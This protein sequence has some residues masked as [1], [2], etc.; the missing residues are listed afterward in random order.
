MPPAPMIGR[1]LKQFKI[2]SKLGEGGMGVVYRAHDER[3]ERDVAVKV[4]HPRADQGEAFL[5]RFTREAQAASALNH[6]NILT[7][8]EIG[9]FEGAP[10]L[11]AEH[12]DGDSLQT[13]LVRGPIDSK[14]AIDIAQQIASALGA[15][16]RA[17]LMHRD[18]KPANVMLRQDGLAKLVDFGLA[19]PLAMSS[20]SDVETAAITRAGA[21][22]GTAAYM[23]PEQARGEQVDARSDLFSLGAVLYEMLSGASPFQRGAVGS[24]FDAVLN[25]EPSPIAA[26]LSLH[27]EV[28]WIVARALEKDPDLR[29]QSAEDL[30]S[31]LLRLGGRLSTTSQPT[32]LAA[33]TQ[34]D[35]AQPDS[36]HEGTRKRYL[37][38][39]LAVAAG[40]VL[41]LLAANLYR[42]PVSEGTASTAAVSYQ[43]VTEESGLEL[44]PSLSP[45]GRFIAYHAGPLENRDIFL[46]RVGGG[47]TINLT[48]HSEAS[49]TEPAFSPDGEHIAFR[50]ERSG[51]GIF[52]MG[53]TGEDVRRVLHFGHHPSWSPDGTRLA[54]C[55]EDIDDPGRR[56]TG[57][58]IWVVTASSGKAEQIPLPDG[59]QPNWSRDGKKL[60]YWAV[61]QGGQRDLFMVDLEGGE[62]QQLTQEDSIDWNPVWAPDGQHLYFLSDRAGT[63][64][65][66]RMR[67]DSA[68]GATSDPKQVPT[69]SLY[70]QNISLSADGSRLAYVA[71]HREA[72]L[73]VFAFDPEAGEPQETRI[74]ATQR[75]RGTRLLSNPSVSNQG[76]IVMDSTGANQE[77]LF[78]L[79]PTGQLRKLTDDPPRDRAARFLNDATIVFFSDRSGQWNVWTINVDG[80]N[81]NQLTNFSEIGA[82]SP[83]PSPDGRQLLVNR[84][85]GPPT[86]L[87]LSQDGR[88]AN[89]ESELNWL[90]IPDEVSAPQDA[91]GT[92]SYYMWVWSWSTDDELLGFE[93]TLDHATFLNKS[94]RQLDAVG[95][96][97]TW[98]PDGKRFLF[99]GSDNKTLLLTEINSPSKSRPVLSVAADSLQGFAL[100]PDGQSLAVISHQSTADVWMLEQPLN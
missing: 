9:E 4:I 22:V 71:L 39:V 30:S 58:E 43:H 85:H 5:Q 44:F 78:L 94:V 59:V 2:L 87:E 13:R 76:S 88:M 89:S 69:P 65:I 61:H 100:S 98:L 57:S 41:G 8:Y 75:L 14:T 97:G 27:E 79:M 80:S 52:V 74:D 12:I 38:P 3:L 16:H 53:A 66:W 92:D 95:S 37:L 91:G 70:T 54:V 40:A 24:T 20:E 49:D 73:D 56:G 35:P 6:P 48:E 62:P 36:T 26:R 15:A 99:V 55:T 29:F 82:Q 23:S 21:V 46:R 50:S 63:M 60:A 96:R 84:M 47:T 67:V 51:G 28:D 83:I 17:G 19:K 45:D 11:V 33:S 64:A 10:Y 90:K 68:T 18:I 34:A 31:A 42:R 25:H 1:H 77:D 32:H 81:L 7:I 86:L 72:A 93:G